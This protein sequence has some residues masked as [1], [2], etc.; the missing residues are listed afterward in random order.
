MNIISFLPCYQTEGEEFPI[1]FSQTRQDIKFLLEKFK[2]KPTIIMGDFHCPPKTDTID[3]IIERNGFKSYLDKYPTFRKVGTD[4]FFNL[5][6]CI[7]NTDISL[8]D[9]KV[10]DVA[11][12]VGHMAITYT[13]NINK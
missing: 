7:S 3:D 4:Q 9:V 12:G 11:D 6:K 8:S 2:D 10:H 5:D 1:S 13:L